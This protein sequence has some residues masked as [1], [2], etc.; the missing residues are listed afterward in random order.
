MISEL[1]NQIDSSLKSELEKINRRNHR[2]KKVNNFNSYS[3]YLLYSSLAT[4]RH[5]P[6]VIRSKMKSNTVAVLHDFGATEAE[7]LIYSKLFLLR[8]CPL[9]ELETLCMLA[10][11]PPGATKYYSDSDKDVNLSLIPRKTYQK[12][13]GQYSAF[14]SDLLLDYELVPIFKYKQNNRVWYFCVSIGVQSG[15]FV[16]SRCLLADQDKGDEGYY[17]AECKLTLRSILE[18]F[19]NLDLGAEAEPYD[20]A[21]WKDC[22][23]EYYRKRL[24]H[25]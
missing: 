13:N 4:S 15:N 20:A 9:Y 16:A 21:L 23:H 18:Q 1:L 19:E 17:I 25:V 22:A 6:S 8:D 10:H 12:R 7:N 24:N 2:S 5:I 11:L 14:L 3:D